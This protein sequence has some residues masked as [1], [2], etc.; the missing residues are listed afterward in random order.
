MGGG[1]DFGLRHTQAQLLGA[2]PELLHHSSSVL[3]VVVL[4]ATVH[5]DRLPWPTASVIIAAQFLAVNRPCSG[6]VS[7]EGLDCAVTGASDRA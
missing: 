7:Y 1:R 5:V 6:Q 4:C 3:L 2:T